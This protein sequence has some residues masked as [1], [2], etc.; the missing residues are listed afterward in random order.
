MFD[1]L[2]MCIRDR[3]LTED[4]MREGIRKGLAARGM[5]PVFKITAFKKAKIIV[6]F[7][8]KLESFIYSMSGFAVCQGGVLNIIIVISR[9][10]TCLLYTSV[11]PICPHP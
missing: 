3:S 8:N 6:P 4:E 10:N 11:F 2:K 5:F 1:L 7:L 9:V